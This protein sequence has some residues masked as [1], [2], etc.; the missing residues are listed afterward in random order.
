[1]GRPVIVS[2]CRTAIGKFQGALA[3]LSAPQLGG[4]VVR[5]ALQRAKVAPEAV[6]EV[7]M[8]VVLQAGLGQNPARQSLRLGG[9]PDSVGAV[10]INKVCGS[11]LK[12]VMLAA[13]AIK[14][15]DLK[16][17]VAGGMES[18][19]NAP[20]YLPTA[21]TGMRL[22]HAQA[23]DGIVWDGL[24][25]HYN[26]FHMGSTAELVAQK[27]GVSRVDQDAYA[28]E[29][30]RRAVAA[31]QQGR[32]DAEITP[33][34]LKGKKGDVTVFQRDEGP[35]AD[36]TVESLSRLRPAF[37]REGGTVTAGNA[38]SINDGASALVVC[39]EDWAK[40]HG[41]APIARI[42]GYATGGLSPE[43]V[44][45]APEVA[46]KKLC[47]LL[48]CGAQDFD[49][50]EMNEA[51]SVQMVALQRQLEV[52]PARWNVHGGAVALGHPIGCSG[53][54]VLTTLLHALQ[55]HG[56]QRGLAGLCLGGGN[57][58]VMAV[59]RI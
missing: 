49:L 39:D 33:V 50:V 32:F 3:P 4:I 53:A 20:Y 34:E 23:L 47:A 37:Q 22:G 8:G 5:E 25:D 42:L 2:A 57:A 59:E 9:I 24:W 41:I 54:R 26:D 29:S 40:A 6:D 51:F 17:A 44:M 18:M 28:A 36:S 1:M 52:D 45:M 16:V 58:V 19:S 27:Y 30:H 46:T 35:R 10:T 7:L 14:A 38:S 13:Q 15:G 56:K 11:G 31:Q 12:T 48:Q 21:R 43:W 55:S